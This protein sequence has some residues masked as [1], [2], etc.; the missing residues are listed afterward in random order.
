MT[1]DGD[2][3]TIPD[4]DTAAVL[5]EEDVRLALGD[6]RE[7]LTRHLGSALVK[8]ALYGSRVRGDADPDSDVDVA[9]VVRGL[10]SELRDEILHT[11]AEVEIDRGVPLSTLVIAEAEYGRLLQS[12][13]RIA[14]DIEREGIPL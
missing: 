10:G 13:R 1:V 7:R 12:E 11:V 5:A 4:V 8:L 6:L 2:R 3:P 9:V 14:V